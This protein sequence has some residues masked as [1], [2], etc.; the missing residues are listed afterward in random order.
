MFIRLFSV[1]D[2]EDYAPPDVKVVT[3]LGEE[4]VKKVS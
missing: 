1:L 3:A 4:V 2:D